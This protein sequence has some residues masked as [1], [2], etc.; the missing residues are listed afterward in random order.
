[1]LA[2]S[3]KG[4]SQQSAAACVTT[5]SAPT[6]DS[7]PLTV[8][9]RVHALDALS[10]LP[11]TY[12]Q[13]FGDGVRQFLRPPTPLQLDAYATE[14]DMNDVE[15]VAH[16]TLEVALKA[17]MRRNGRIENVRITGGTRTADFD[18][19]LLAA[20]TAMDTSGGLPP[21]PDSIDLGSDTIP[22]SVTILTNDSRTKLA[23]GIEVPLFQFKTPLRPV[24]RPLSTMPGTAALGYPRSLRGSNI[25]GTA[26][27]SYVVRP[28][29]KADMPTIIAWRADHRE[30]LRTVIEALPAFRFEPLQ[31]E[32]CPVAQ[33]VREPFRFSVE[34]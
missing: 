30:F 14:R 32:G 1:M 16:L 18:D 34:P 6:R 28:D 2:I 24:S 9:L 10:D 15:R 31:V 33:T 19:A 25:S 5:L 27:L 4:L 21:V 12:Q 13:L 26:V 20:I 7:I 3:G 11:E 17:T 22:I 8:G 23:S 29:G